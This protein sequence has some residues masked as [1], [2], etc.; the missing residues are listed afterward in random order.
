MS[1]EMKKLVFLVLLILFLSSIVEALSVREVDDIPSYVTTQLEDLDIIE[2][3]LEELESIIDTS[4]A[5]KLLRDSRS[6]LLEAQEEYY[7][8]DYDLS[9]SKY[10]QAQAKMGDLKSELDYLYEN[11][12]DN[13]S[14]IW[15]GAAIIIV[16][17]V[18]I[19]IVKYWKKIKD[20]LKGKKVEEEEE[21]IYYQPRGGKYRT[22][23]Y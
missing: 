21:V 1:D 19:A 12:P 23:Y 18:I 8:E 6:L 5:K 7:E 17:I 2:S 14:I 3:R 9:E 10:R 20:K 16:L 22:E 13:S 4:E 15:I 11:A